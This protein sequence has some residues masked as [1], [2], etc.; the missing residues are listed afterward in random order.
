MPELQVE[1][2]CSC[3][4]ISSD[5]AV[6]HSYT[7]VISS[8]ALYKVVATMLIVGHTPTGARLA[9]QRSGSVTDYGLRHA[10]WQEACRHSKEDIIPPRQFLCPQKD[11]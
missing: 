6:Q 11:I 4:S 3:S 7:P 10:A 1:Q 5:L 8:E 2:T 9:T